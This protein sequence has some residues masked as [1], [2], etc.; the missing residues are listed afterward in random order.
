MWIG[1]E[2]SAKVGFEEEF[3]EQRVVVEADGATLEGALIMIET[4]R[5]QAAVV[6]ARD[7]GCAPQDLAARFARFLALHNTAVLLMDMRGC[8]ESVVHEGPDW[9]DADTDTLARDLLAGVEALREQE[10]VNPDRVGVWGRDGGA[11]LAVRAAALGDPAFVVGT[12]AAWNDAEP[13]TPDR[14]DLARVDEPLLWIVSGPNPEEDWSVFLQDLAAAPHAEAVTLSGGLRDFSVS[15]GD[16]NARE[17]RWLSN[18]APDY[19]HLAL[20]WIEER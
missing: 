2:T 19:A 10:G 12:S 3:I 11:V 14:A 4:Q 20:P 8:G 15:A 9:R 1:P 17:N 6:M 13:E 7:P 16:E 18:L 5:S